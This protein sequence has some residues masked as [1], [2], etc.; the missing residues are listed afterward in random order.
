MFVLLAV[1]GAIFSLGF[2]FQG[3]NVHENIKPVTPVHEEPKSEVI[4]GS[5]PTTPTGAQSLH[6]LLVNAP[7]EEF[8]ML[9]R[10]LA[11][12]KIY[13]GI[14]SEELTGYVFASFAEVKGTNRDTGEIGVYPYLMLNPQFSPPYS[15]DKILFIWLCIYHEYTHYQ[16]WKRYTYE[17]N[18]IFRGLDSP[19]EAMCEQ[20]WQAE[21]EAHFKTCELSNS[22]G[23]PFMLG[24]SDYCL[25]VNSEKEFTQKFLKNTE[26]QIKASVPDCKTVWEGHKILEDSKTQ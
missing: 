8:R 22:W 25:H 15:E 21:Y 3:N 11:E 1:L 9:D 5:R 23:V 12:G 24:K 10:D 2:L 17:E 18:A 14:L 26:L 16:Q 13:P 6:D 20:L 4:L 19:T 7:A